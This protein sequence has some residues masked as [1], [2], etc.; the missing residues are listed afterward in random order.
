MLGPS[1]PIQKILTARR[2][3][4]IGTRSSARRS[5]KLLFPGPSISVPVVSGKRKND[6]SLESDREVAFKQKEL[7]SLLR[8][9]LSE[10]TM[11]KVKIIEAE[12]SNLLAKEELYWHQRSRA[13]W[14]RAGNKN[15]KFFHLKASAR[16]KKNTILN[17]IDEDGVCHTEADGIHRTVCKYFT[18][19]FSS[20]RPSISDL[21]NASKFINCR[22]DSDM[23]AVLNAHFDA[24][25][26]E[27]GQYEGNKQIISVQTSQIRKF[28]NNLGRLF[29]LSRLFDLEVQPEFGSSDV[30]GKVRVLP[31]LLHL[32]AGV[33]VPLNVT[34][35]WAPSHALLKVNIPFVFRGE[36]ALS[37]LRKCIP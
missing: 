28:V 17:L 16:R 13:D 32:H 37:G 31:K 8:D 7:N 36:D 12:L 22:M 33:D 30:I 21:E 3:N 19:M 35:L 1:S 24:F 15:S 4:K 25:E 20:S 11:A 23:L 2:K 9:N 18:S 6:G 27:D 34:F 10:A 26:K 14:M 5:L 29:F